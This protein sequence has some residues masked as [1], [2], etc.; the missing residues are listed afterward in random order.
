MAEPIEIEHIEEDG[1]VMNV[2]VLEWV[3]LAVGLLF[4][5]GAL[6][7][8]QASFETK[9]EMQLTSLAKETASNLK[10]ITREN[11]FTLS[12]LK[13]DIKRNELRAVRL[14]T[15]LIQTSSDVN[16]KLAS[17]GKGV[18]NINNSLAKL[19][20]IYVSKE[21]A[22]SYLCRDEVDGRLIKSVR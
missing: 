20:Y 8:N 1:G 6:I 4:S 10:V 13:V 16:N 14:E 7:Y 2:R 5:F 19:K 12:S 3:V 18:V 21:E 22:Q 15:N 17:I 11:E 9:T